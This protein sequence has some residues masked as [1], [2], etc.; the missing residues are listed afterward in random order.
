[1]QQDLPS[2]SQEIVFSQ[3]SNPQSSEKWGKV[4][5]AL[6]E[7]WSLIIHTGM[8]T[9]QKNPVLLKVG[10]RSQ[11]PGYAELQM[12]AIFPELGD[13]SPWGR[14]WSPH[15]P[16]LGKVVLLTTL[17]AIP[18]HDCGPVYCRWQVNLPNKININKFIC[19][20]YIMQILWAIFQEIS[21]R[22][23]ISP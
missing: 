6:L 23:R 12:K 13:K 4:V 3:I 18:V 8:F 17:V 7:D 5:K 22:S 19:I 15:P 2:I 9:T 1:M 16:Y 20:A 14:K 11:N 21:F 10:N